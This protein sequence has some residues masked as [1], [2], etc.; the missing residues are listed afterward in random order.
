MSVENGCDPILLS[1]S[2]PFSLDVT[3][4]DPDIWYTVLISDVTD[5]D[6]P[7]AI[8]C[9]DCHN[10]T[11]PHYFWPSPLP[12][13]VPVTSTASQ[14]SHEMELGK[15]RRVS[16]FQ[17]FRAYNNRLV[18]YS[19]HRIM[20]IHIHTFTHMHKLLLALTLQKAK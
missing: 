17:Y 1:W 3:G 4:V 9:T 2:P 19:M 7:T 11:Q 20:N 6:N 18:R 12:T 15:K 14:S 16:I 10:L 5:E 8:P 13:P